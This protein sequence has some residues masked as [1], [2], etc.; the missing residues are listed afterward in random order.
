MKTQTYT[1]NSHIGF[2]RDADDR[3]LVQ[4]FRDSMTLF[5]ARIARLGTLS[6]VT[7]D[8]EADSMKVM[9]DVLIA[10][11]QKIHHQKK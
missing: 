8:A 10:A 7:T 4:H 9:L 3:I 1:I 11:K 5:K 2:I 6:H